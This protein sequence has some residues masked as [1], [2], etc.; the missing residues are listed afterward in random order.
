MQNKISV[1]D[2]YLPLMIIVVFTFILYANTFTNDYALDDL[3]VINGNAFTKK[4]FSGLG[5]IFSYD[6]FT[7]F[8]GKQ[9]KLVAGG[10]YRPLSMAT[11]AIEYGF[12]KDFKPG[13][14][15]FLNVLFYAITGILLFLILSR[16]IKPQK[17][18]LKQWHLGIP[19]IATLLFLAH[20]LH[21]E[22]V[23]NIKG[24]DEIFALM[25]SLLTV[26]LILLY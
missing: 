17:N 4:G 10:R 18:K 14:S 21:T 16:L 12:F 1:T 9:K 2:K 13:F 26:W 15:H 20:P 23:A 6:S 25:F 8:F 19:F 7:G 3:I 11:F 5:E 24:R 22:V